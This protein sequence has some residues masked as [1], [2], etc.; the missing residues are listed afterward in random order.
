MSAYPTLGAL[1]TMARFGHETGVRP[2]YWR[3]HEQQYGL[4]EAGLM[5]YNTLGGWRLWTSI[6]YYK[7]ETC[8]VL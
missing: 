8:R 4:R 7:Y 1:E 2:L 6:V 5:V 3:V